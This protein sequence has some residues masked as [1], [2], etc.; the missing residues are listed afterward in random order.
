MT[1]TRVDVHGL[2][3]R[4][5]ECLTEMFGPLEE[6]PPDVVEQDEAR[7]GDMGLEKEKRRG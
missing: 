2:E 4:C 1:A 7:Y 3:C 5:P 6:M